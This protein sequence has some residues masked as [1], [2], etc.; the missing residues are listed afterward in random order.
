M[1]LLQKYWQQNQLASQN[2]KF[3][4]MLPLEILLKTQ[5]K[6]ELSNLRGK[7]RGFWAF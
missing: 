3:Q 5:N 6:R 1:K 4:V 7:L 2:Q